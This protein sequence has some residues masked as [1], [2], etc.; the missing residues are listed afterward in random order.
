LEGNKLWHLAVFERWF[1]LN[2]DK[3]NPS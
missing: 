1:Q 3:K 2:I